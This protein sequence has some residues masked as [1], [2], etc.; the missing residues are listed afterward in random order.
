MKCSLKIQL[1][2]AF[3]QEEAKNAKKMKAE[4]RKAASALKKLTNASISKAKMLIEVKIEQQKEKK[5]KS[6]KTNIQRFD[7]Q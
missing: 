1:L 3:E 2:N 7:E 4:R 5:E 6:Y